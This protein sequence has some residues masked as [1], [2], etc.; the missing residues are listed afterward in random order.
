MQS[1]PRRVAAAA[2][3]RVLNQAREVAVVCS[4]L[5]ADEQFIAAIERA[6]ARGVRVYLLVAAE[7]RLLS[8]PPEHWSGRSDNWKREVTDGFKKTLRR[9]GGHTLIRAGDSFHAKV[10]IADPDTTPAGVLYTAN[11]TKEALERNQ[12]LAVSLAAGQVRDVM[13]LLRWGFW[14]LARQEILEPNADTL[15]AISPLG[16]IEHPL[17]EH[18]LCTTPASRTIRESLLAAIRAEGR[19]LEISCFGWSADHDVVGALIERAIAG[20]RVTAFARPRASSMPAL[21]KLARAGATVLGFDHLHAKALRTASGASILMTANLQQHGMDEGFE[22]GVA[23]NEGDA[24]ALKAV[25]S[26]WRHAAEWE[27]LAEPTLGRAVGSVQVFENNRL[28]EGNIEDGG[29]VDHGRVE[30]ASVELLARAVPEAPG[31]L[32][33]ARS[34]TI[35]AEFVPPVLPHGAKELLQTVNDGVGGTRTR[36]YSPRAYKHGGRTL[37]A[38]DNITE[39]DAAVDLKHLLKADAIVFG[40]AHQ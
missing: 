13:A 12:E 4:F 6:A 38:I 18:V 29:V 32:P 7:G 25:F 35:R 37:I 23:L 39:L 36:S 33:R 22:L 1:G 20:V 14:E 24:E 8:E 27:L 9:L 34:V 5:L 11:L 15:G 31:P 30:I 2:G 21:L 40:G 10:V 3:I 26:E 28:V 16:Q 19:E 17:L